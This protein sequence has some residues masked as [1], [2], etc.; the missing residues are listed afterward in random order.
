MTTQESMPS[1]DAVARMPVEERQKYLDARLREFVAYAYKNAPAVKERF[2]KAGVKPEGIKGADDLQKMSILRKD[3]LIELQKKNPPFGGYLAVPIS[4][5]ERVY[6]SPGPIYDPQRKKGFGSPAGISSDFGKGQIVA[7]TWSYHLVPAGLAIDDALRKMGCTVLPA[8][9]GNTE[10]LVQI[11]HDLRVSGFCGTPS[12]L[13][14]VLDKAEAMGCDVK[15]DLNLKWAMVTGEMGGD[16]LRRIFWEKYGI[17]CVG[18]DAYATADIGGIASGCQA[19]AGMHVNP[20]LIVELVD[21]STGKRVSPGEVGEV[22]VTPFDEVYPLI[23]FGT[24]DLSS[25]ITEPCSCGRTT[26]RLTKILGRSGD[27][28]RVRGMFVHPKQT[29]EVM[30]LYSVVS[31]YQLVVTRP[32]HRDEMSLKVEL[33]D[34]KINKEKLRAGLDKDFRGICKVRFDRVEFVPKGTIPQDAKPIVD[35]RTY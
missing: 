25:Y 8:G 30:S 32:E 24:G 33:A 4:S 20:E 3:D 26:Y 7:N 1:A 12:Y 27:A 9:T 19:N 15:K 11:M 18:G 22:V 2:D 14:T 21:S 17:S 5:L 35:Q 34:E 16:V 23:R 13:K 29:E 10:N 28:V 6:Q 31:R